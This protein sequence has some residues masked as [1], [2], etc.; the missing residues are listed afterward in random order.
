MNVKWCESD[1]QFQ[2]RGWYW[3]DLTRQGWFCLS[4]CSQCLRVAL[5]VSYACYIV[6]SYNTSNYTL[7]LLLLFD[8]PSVLLVVLTKVRRA[9]LIL[10]PVCFL[11]VWVRLSNT[12]SFK[13][14]R[15]TTSKGPVLSFHIRY[16]WY[17]CKPVVSM[18]LTMS[19]WGIYIMAF[20]I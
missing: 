14:F 18:L 6:S 9:D 19:Q 17:I 12:D 20:Y 13:Q 5:Q 2:R 8:W 7:C 16:I 4:I 11:D 15:V 1:V 3:W 10:L